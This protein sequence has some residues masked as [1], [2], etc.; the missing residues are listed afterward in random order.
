M[1]GKHSVPGQPGTLALE[2]HQSH[3]EELRGRAGPL[4]RLGTHFSTSAA[5]GRAL[6]AIE[7]KEIA[8]K[9]H[10]AGTARDGGVVCASVPLL[11]P[12]WRVEA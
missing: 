3:V 1:I 7:N 6:R 9:A 4:Q 11:S 8:A 5:A 10:I 12:G 2:G